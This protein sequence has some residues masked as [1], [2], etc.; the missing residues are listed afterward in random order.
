VDCTELTGEQYET[1]KAK[2][3]DAQ[4]YFRSVMR[5][6]E[7]IGFPPDDP[8][9]REYRE[10][11]SSLQSLWVCLHYLQCGMKP[12]MACWPTKPTRFVKPPPASDTP[13]PD[14]G[15]C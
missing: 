9:L 11:E 12:E 7:V 13:A 2:I 15:R 14:S 6:M 5:R 4:T 10:I 1:L 8:L 3:R